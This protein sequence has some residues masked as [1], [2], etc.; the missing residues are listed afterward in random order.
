MT[1]NHRAGGSIPS[2]PILPLAF[3]LALFSACS[4]TSLLIGDRNPPLLASS[5]PEN[6]SSGI[7]LSQPIVLIFTE[8]MDQ[9][10]T[11]SAISLF[12]SLTVRFEWSLNRQIVTLFHDTA[13]SPS[14]T[15]TLRIATTAR[16][17]AGNRLLYPVEIRFTTS[18][19]SED[20]QPPRVLFTEPG[21]NA[22]DVP[23]QQIVRILFSEPMNSADTENAIIVQPPIELNFQW[24]ETK[25]TLSATPG[26]RFQ[27]GTLYRWEISTS[28]RDL[29]GN[30]L[31]APYQFQF[32]TVSAP[33]VQPVNF[34]VKVTDACQAA[35][36]G[37]Y[38]IVEDARGTLQH[39]VVPGELQTVFTGIIPPYTATVA[40][41]ES[42][43]HEPFLS[44]FV[45]TGEDSIYFWVPVHQDNCPPPPPPPPGEI[46]KATLRGVL[47]NFEGQRAEIYTTNGGFNFLSFPTTSFQISDVYPGKLTLYAYEL[48]EQ[49]RKKRMGMLSLEVRE[50]EVRE[51]ISLEFTADYSLLLS[52]NVIYPSNF[53]PSSYSFLSLHLSLSQGGIIS[54][55][56]QLNSIPAG[57]YQVL[58]PDFQRLPQVNPATDVIRFSA[59]ASQKIDDRGTPDISDDH[60]RAMSLSGSRLVGQILQ[61]HPLDLVFPDFPQLLSPSDQQN[62]PRNNFL[63]QWKPG[64]DTPQALFIFIET[65]QRKRVWGISIPEP[66]SLTQFRLPLLPPEVEPFQPEQVYLIQFFASFPNSTFQDTGIQIQV[67]R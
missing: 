30:P 20:T 41:R 13:F 10:N 57:P 33:P 55:L 3:A 24:N 46:Q 52:G 42:P 35:L 64:Q 22:Q 66:A 61:G 5:L 18:A 16:D 39:Q 8:P 32:T 63:F 11:E 26:T 40:Y 58:L 56:N 62:I 38:I 27:E 60:L 44:T 15:Y 6:G 9:A 59:S 51:G 7:A 28:A 37:A 31:S 23:I 2:R 29:A 21:N 47:S 36:P 43:T 34:T 45:L 53:F 49:N 17:L 48:D 12:P 14:T 4:G 19:Q 1:L 50:G 25:T 67:M 65:P 54:W